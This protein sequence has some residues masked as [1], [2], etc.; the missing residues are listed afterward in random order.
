MIDCFS[1]VGELPFGKLY[2]INF[3]TYLYV[4]ESN[5][6]SR[7]ATINY[8]RRWVQYNHGYNNNYSRVLNDS[9]FIKLFDFERAKFIIK[10][11]TKKILLLRDLIVKDIE[12][13]ILK[14]I[15]DKY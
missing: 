9:Y 4:N 12:V 11:H 15:I 1:Y 10:I 2:S 7:Y 8:P 3:K 6:Y 14:C 13:C 5:Y